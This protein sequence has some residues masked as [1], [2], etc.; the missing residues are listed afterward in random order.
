MLEVIIGIDPD[1]DKNGFARYFI[2]DDLFQL[3]NLNLF[4]TFN[5]LLDM[6]KAFN[7]IVLLESGHKVKKTWQRKTTGVIKDVGRNNEIGSQLE[8]FMIDHNIPH[9]TINPFGGSKVNHEL[10]CKITGWDKKKR[11]N[12][13]TRVAGL[14]VSNYKSK[15]K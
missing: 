9:K 2:K 3:K 4:E 12:P 6:H 13:E 7:V 8:K 5:M 1:V 10:F 15:L 11:T 14:L